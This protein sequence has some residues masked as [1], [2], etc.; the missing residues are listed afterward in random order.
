MLGIII[1]CTL[2]ACIY[3]IFEGVI[4][5]KYNNEIR[6]DEQE[7]TE[8]MARIMEERALEE[9]KLKKKQE[10]MEKRKRAQA[11]K[12]KKTKEEL[13]DKYIEVMIERTEIMETYIKI[14]RRKRNVKITY[15]KKYNEDY[16]KI[17]FWDFLLGHTTKSQRYAIFQSELLTDYIRSE[18]RYSYGFDKDGPDAVIFNSHYKGN[19]S[20]KHYLQTGKFEDL[21]R[22]SSM[23]SSDFIHYFANVTKGL[24]NLSVIAD[25]FENNVQLMQIYENIKTEKISKEEKIDKL[26]SSYKESYINVFSKELKKDDI[27]LIMLIIGK[28][29]KTQKYNAEEYNITSQQQLNELIINKL[30]T[31][32]EEEKIEWIINFLKNERSIEKEW[33]NNIV[34]NIDDILSKVKRTQKLDALGFSSFSTTSF[35][36]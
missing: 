21:R 14:L 25:E 16:F 2:I 22:Y 20:L 11:E 7:H 10:A 28:K 29:K 4:G 3:V 19:K 32:S 13:K 1:G 15:L 34:I 12:H 35:R 30:S 31:L 8:K 18:G 9:E 23:R 26:Y 17:L 24:I 33:K 5:L 36:V 27:E 6:K